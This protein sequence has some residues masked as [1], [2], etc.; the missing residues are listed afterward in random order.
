MS[1]IAKSYWR[2]IQRGTRAFEAV[3]DSMK[4]EV[5]A[6]ARAD[7]AAGLLTGEQYRELVGEEYAPDD[8]F[9]S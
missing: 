5:R 2:S 3:P 4:D 6:L 7:A 8:D 1:A 9:A